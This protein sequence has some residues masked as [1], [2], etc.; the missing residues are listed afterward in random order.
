MN[1][2]IHEYFQGKHLLITGASGYLASNLVKSLKNIPCTLRRLSRKS[3]LPFL[4]G[5]VV[6]EDMQGEISDASVWSKAMQGID[7]VFHFASQTSVYLADKDPENDYQ[8]N[9]LPML[10]MLEACKKSENCPDILFAGTSTQV[11]LPQDLPVS[12]MA[13][14]NPITIYDL[15]KLM[16]ESY[17]KCYSRMGIVRGVILRLTN[18]YGPGPKSSSEDRGFLN[19]MIRRA[20]AGENLTLYGEG[21][22]IRDYIYIADVL[23]AFLQASV[24]MSSLNQKH[25]VLGSGKGYTISEALHHIVDRVALK[26]RGQVTVESITPPQGL[27]PIEKRSFVADSQSFSRL[28]GWQPQNSLIKGIDQTLEA[29]IAEG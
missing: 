12:E 21:E 11:G 10:Y 2:L 4:N 5:K 26:M 18:V 27:S 25:F 19:S 17:L 1:P 15:H 28:T 9:V 13:K 3:S 22:H 24:N 20:L 16:A 29:F 23:S 8:V 14:D 6:I 7:V